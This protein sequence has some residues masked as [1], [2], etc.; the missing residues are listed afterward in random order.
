MDLTFQVPMQ[1]C[2]LKHWTLPWS[3]GTFTTKHCFYF[4]PGFL[5]FL[6]LFLICLQ[7]H[8]EHLLTLGV[9]LPLT[10]LFPL[11]YCSWGF[12]GKNTEVVCHSLIQWTTFCQNSP[13]WLIC[14]GWLST[15]WL[16]AP[17]SYRRLWYM[18]SFWLYFWDWGFHF[19]D[20]ESS[21][22]AHSKVVTKYT[23][24]KNLPFQSF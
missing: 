16:I 3:P 15:A 1:Y 21:A 2:S 18:L 5:F 13:P 10:Y 22:L 20:C 24:D 6:E 12:Q 17:L 23:E 9:H 8:I 7:W 11:S 4:G 19:G 14:L